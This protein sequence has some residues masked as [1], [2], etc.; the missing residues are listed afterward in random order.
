MVSIADLRVCVQC[1]LDF[2]DAALPLVLVA[3][4][5]RRESYVLAT[6]VVCV[7]ASVLCN[8]VVVRGPHG[9]KD[10]ATAAVTAGTV[11]MEHRLEK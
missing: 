1:T 2:R 8:Y 5:G 3:G 4:V 11:Q 6:T 10:A 7:Y 9:E